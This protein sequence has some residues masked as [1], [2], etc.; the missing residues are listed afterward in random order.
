MSPYGGQGRE[1]E[2]IITTL[3]KKLSDK[4]DIEF[5]IVLNWL[6]TKL[7]YCLLRSAILCLRGSRSVRK[8]NVDTNEMEIHETTRRHC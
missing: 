3:A 5:G 6:R 7:S 2:M 1:T 8:L 4:K